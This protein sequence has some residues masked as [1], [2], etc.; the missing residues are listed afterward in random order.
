[1]RILPALLV[2]LLTGCDVGAMIAARS[3]RDR[4]SDDE[5]SPVVQPPVPPPDL[6]YHVW[7]AD[8]AD[9]PAAAQQEADLRTADG[10]PDPLVWTEAGT[11]SQ[12]KT[13]APSLGSPYNAILIQAGGARVWHVD[14]VELLDAFGNVTGTASGTA[15]FGWVTAPDN[16]LRPPD[17][18]NADTAATSTSKAFVFF[19]SAAAL[20]AFR[21]Y[22]HADQRASGDVEWVSSWDDAGDESAGGAAIDATGNLV[23]TVSDGAGPHDVQVLRFPSGGGAPTVI[24]TPATGVAGTGG[25]SPAFD[26]SGN[27]Y[28]A[29]TTT[30]DI[31]LRKYDSL[32]APVWTAPV[33]TL[34]VDGDRVAA[35]GLA[36]DGA[37]SPIIA[38]GAAVIGGGVDHRIWKRSAVDGS[39][40]WNQPLQQADTNDTWWRA[41]AVGGM[42]DVFSVGDL[43]SI[44]TG[45]SIF[46]RRSTSAGAETWSQQRLEDGSTSTADLAHAVLHDPATD[47]VYVGGYFSTAAQGRNRALLKLTGGGLIFESVNQNGPGNGD[48]EILDLAVD[49]DGTLYAAGVETAAGAN[50]NLW[51]RKYDATGA[52]VWTRTYDGPGAGADRAVSLAIQGDLLLVAGTETLSG[53][54]TDVIVRAYRK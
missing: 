23:V 36:V 35:N 22:A 39:E 34:L 54:T 6:D 29:A 44:V 3:L 47:T 25:H 9:D 32:L 16:I 10:V 40:I 20:G 48:D 26:S 49:S 50:A 37:G 11:G 33:G 52:V 43:Y 18:V 42:D 17:G 14:A 19:R 24:D 8:L 21:V 31:L 41:A 51:V 45:L 53:G 30:A 13:F 28:V 27:L 38:G 4:D 2:L 12:S 15:W 5:E 1:M 46:A 7:V